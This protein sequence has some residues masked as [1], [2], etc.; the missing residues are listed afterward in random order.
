MIKHLFA[1]CLVPVLFCTIT[2]AQ[3][4]DPVISRLKN[5]ADSLEQEFNNRQ[6]I[7]VYDRKIGTL[8]I[9]NI[10]PSTGL[11]L[12]AEL[13][14]D[15]DI[16]SRQEFVLDN[17]GPYGA[18][19][20]QIPVEITAEWKDTY[21]NLS[22][23][24][25]DRLVSAEQILVD[26]KPHH[27]TALGGTVKIDEEGDKFVYLG[28]LSSSGKPW[29]LGI[30]KKTGFIASYKVGE[31]EYIV[32][33]VHPEGWTPDDISS[34]VLRSDGIVTV[35]SPKGVLNYSTSGDGT[36]YISIKESE[37]A[38]ITGVMTP[39]ATDTDFHGRGPQNCYGKG[40]HYGRVGKY[41]QKAGWAHSNMRWFSIKDA[42]G[43]GL[44]F[45]SDFEFLA[46][47][48]QTPE[49]TMFSCT[50]LYGVTAFYFF[51]LSI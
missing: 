43:E 23:Y 30:D 45:E 21:L 11:N 18:T 4:A 44:V 34:V 28:T 27:R 38:T 9:F 33:P 10:S 48:G 17:L 37:T 20:I 3:D 29:V 5:E 42:E 47:T 32:S 51:P 2:K 8:D 13:Q 50:T 39:T 22:Y 7:S 14:S 26:K 15:C 31:K 12:V 16:V 1:V 6:I 24:S 35:T 41:S 40:Y 19:K 36:V 49:G 25:G 46:R